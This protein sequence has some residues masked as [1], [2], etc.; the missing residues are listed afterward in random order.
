MLI[1][2]LNNEKIAI[3]LSICFACMSTAFGFCEYKDPESALRAIHI[4]HEYTLG[5]KKL[6]VS[7]L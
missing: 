7:V 4:L 3:L 2:F 6:L 5:D 1:S